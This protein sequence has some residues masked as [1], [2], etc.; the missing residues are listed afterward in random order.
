M[1]DGLASGMAEAK[2]SEPEASAPMPLV[3]EVPVR[4]PAPRQC[5]CVGSHIFF[6]G[7][8]PLRP[9]MLGRRAVHVNAPESNESNNAFQP[10]HRLAALTDLSQFFAMP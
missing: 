10:H 8:E 2:G 7:R 6:L 9:N 1:T 3:P 4:T 5:P